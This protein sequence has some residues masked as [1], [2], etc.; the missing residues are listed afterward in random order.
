MLASKDFT[1]RSNT[2][3]MELVLTLGDQLTEDI[4]QAIKKSSVYGLF[5]DKVTNLSNNFQLVTFIKYYDQ[6]FRDARTCFVDVSDV[7]EGPV[8]T[9]ATAETT[10]DCLINLLNS[11]DFEI[12]NAKA[13]TSDG[14]SVMTGHQCGV[15]GR[16][17]EHENCQTMLSVH[18]ICH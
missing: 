16:L 18:C 11:L 5:T 12:Q 10:R 9:T 15:A 4:I 3:L 6:N 14:A 8:D 17:S 7:L 1:K 13:F 2:V